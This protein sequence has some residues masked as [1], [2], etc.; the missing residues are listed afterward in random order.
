MGDVREKWI[1][2]GEKHVAGEEDSVHGDTT[3][4]PKKSSADLCAVHSSR[5]VPL[6]Q[7]S[8]GNS[9]ATSK[10]L[11]SDFSIWVS[12]NFRKIIMY[13]IR[14]MRQGEGLCALD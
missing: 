7:W 6:I 8:R 14:G 5:F 9:P 3:F 12:F 11:M 4:Y 1:S 10:N 13:A 2:G